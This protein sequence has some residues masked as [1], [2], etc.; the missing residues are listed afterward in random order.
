MAIETILVDTSA[1]YALLD[2][3]EAQHEQARDAWTGL[4]ETE[5]PLL[6]H[7]YVL[8]ETLALT[9]RRLGIEAVR[10]LH[11]DLLPVLDVAWVGD[12]LHHTAVEA[13]LASG[14]RSISLVDRVSFALMRQRGIQTAFAFDDDFSREG[15]NIVGGNRKRTGRFKRSG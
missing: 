3:D 1:L 14:S 10:A 7:N 11:Q 6:T 15:F 2:R 9:Q 4:M 13:L 8:V 5:T 12:D